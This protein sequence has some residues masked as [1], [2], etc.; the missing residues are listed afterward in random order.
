M[1]AGN[2]LVSPPQ[3]LQNGSWEKLR[4]F[5]RAWAETHASSF[6]NARATW[7]EF[8]TSTNGT[9]EVSPPNLLFGYWPQEVERPP[10]WIIDTI[11]PLLL[12]GAISP[13]FRQNV[14]RCLAARP[15]ETADFQIGVMFSRNIQAVRLCVFDLPADEVFP[16]LDEVGWNGDRD[17][18]GE[19][20]EAFQPYA[21]FIGLHL[22]VGEK[23][24]PHI[25]V[26]PNFVA[27]CWARQPHMEPRWK[28][29]F[30]QLLKRGL[31]I[32]EKRDALLAW[33]GH[34]S[35]L[36]GDQEVLLLRGLSHLKVVLRPGA[37]AVAKA[38]FGIAHR[39]MEIQA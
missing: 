33:I 22:D 7:L 37:Q 31:L 29:Q 10:E 32:P 5:Y 16:Y 23:I 3:E 11:I 17:E 36:S 13:E 8:D 39:A 21:D 27:G 25:G 35:L 38:Y 34:Q 26:E 12:G 9:A 4:G 24:Y 28:G 30:E 6:E 1:L 20:L 18:L 19:Y 2:H 14:A 15:R